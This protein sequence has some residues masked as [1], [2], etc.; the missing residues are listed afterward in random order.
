MTC[1]AL[2]KREGGRRDRRWVEGSL[3]WS[4]LTFYPKGK[5]GELPIPFW[6]TEL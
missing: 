3:V 1:N 2:L 4:H 6:L 5:S